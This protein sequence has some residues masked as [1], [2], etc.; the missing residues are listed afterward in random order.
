MSVKFAIIMDPIAS[1]TPYKDTN[2]ALLLAAQALGY[3]C[4]YL[5]YHQ[6][7]IKDKQGYA[8]CQAITV[9]DD[10]QN[11]YQLGDVCS[12]AL[13]EFDLIMMR[14][15]PP[16][17]LQYIYCTQILSLAPARTR[18]INHPQ[19]LRD[20]NEKLFIA[21]FP[22]CMPSTLVSANATEIISFIDEHQDVIMKPLDGMGGQGIFRLQQHDANMQTAIEL[23]TNRQ[24]K[25]VMLQPY[26]KALET[27]GDKR[28]L[29][30]NGKPVS[31]ALA[32]HPAKNQTRANIASGGHGEVVPL[33]ERDRWL[34]DKIGPQLRDMGLHF[35]GVDVIGDY[36]TEINV[37]SPTCVREIEKET[38]LNI[39]QQILATALA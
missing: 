31:H 16:V 23:L 2:F 30:I 5:Q 33:T 9:R 10:S 6:L 15:D 4:Y 28:I 13:A 27:S 11:Y 3:A 39:C 26:L 1:I 7:Q 17:D 22:E 32:R 34:I 18:V 14:K 25:P 35:V 38:G 29:V 37:T 12:M 19:A 21:Q 36:V 8:T 24:Q 20:V